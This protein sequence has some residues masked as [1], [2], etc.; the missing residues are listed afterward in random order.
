VG[1]TK[2]LV[3]ETGT[4]TLDAAGN[5]GLR[6]TL[7]TA[8]GDATY[9]K[10]LAEAWFDA[11]GI[12]IG[13][14]CYD[15]ATGQYDGSTLSGS[16]AVKVFLSDDDV[17]TNTNASADLDVGGSGTLT[18][19]GATKKWGTVQ[20]LYDSTYSGD[21]LEWW[22]NWKTLAVY[23]AHG[24]TKRG[25]EPDAGVYASDVIADVLSREAPGLPVDE[26]EATSFVI[27]QLVFDSPTA[28]ED[29]IGSVN[30]FHLYR[31]G[32]YDQGFFWRAPN[33]DR[34][35][36]EARLGD[37]A[38][39]SLEG[40][41]DAGTFNGVVVMYQDPYGKQRVVG[42]TGYSPA[43]STSADLVDSTESNPA[44]QH[45]LR[46]YGLLQVSSSQTDTSAI[47]LGRVWLAEQQLPSR[48]GSIILTG[49]VRHPTEGDVPVWR[50]RA[51]DWIR[52]SDRPGDVAREITSTDYDDDSQTVTCSVGGM[53]PRL[54]A[55]LAAQQ[56][57]MVG[58]A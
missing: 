2:Y 11:R 29:V 50:V 48:R 23:G 47:Q 9:R 57:Q 5:D 6:Q 44:N 38:K 28:A 1:A 24:L 19:S 45:G 14:V 27:P 10:G 55:M 31:W 56:V 22:A 42:P 33:P 26:I 36:W 7:T 20:V 54:E 39:L 8:F 18:A 53:P 51:G 3:S 35:T 46:R 4:V 52:V 13:S 49:R 58:L 25:T 32:V 15:V 30:A 17:H 43:D 16:W 34:L 21:D 40:D 12:E 37:G 41:S